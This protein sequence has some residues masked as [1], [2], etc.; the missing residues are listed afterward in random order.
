MG[1][2][3]VQAGTDHV[4]GN[5]KM[6]CPLSSVH[7]LPIVGKQNVST[8]IV[9]LFCVGTPTAVAWGIRSIIV[10]TTNGM[11]WT[12]ALSYISKKIGEG[13]TPTF[14]YNDSA[15]TI[16]RETVCI[17]IVATSFHVSP[18]VVFG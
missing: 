16:I 14:A 6:F 17:W 10:Y 13:V 3:E 9:H 1:P 4:G 5:I 7:R 8:G 12:W 11:I 15:A 2:T 18:D